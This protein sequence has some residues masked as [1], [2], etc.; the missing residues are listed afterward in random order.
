MK[1]AD[2]LQSSV[3]PI[4][5]T[6]VGMQIRKV[7]LFSFIV[8]SQAKKPTFVSPEVMVFHEADRFC[9]QHGGHLAQPAT[10]RDTYFDSREEVSRYWVGV[11]TARSGARFW[12]NGTAVPW[13]HYSYHDRN[14]CRLEKCFMVMRS[15]DH[16]WL[17]ALDD[18]EQ[19]QALCEPSSGA[20]TM[21]EEIYIER[22]VTERPVPEKSL[23]KLP[24]PK[25]PVSRQPLPEQPVS[26]QPVRNQPVP[27]PVPNP[28][29]KTSSVQDIINFSVGILLAV[30]AV[31]FF[32]AILTLIYNKRK[33]AA[34]KRSRPSRK[35][36]AVYAEVV[37]DG[38]QAVPEYLELNAYEAIATSFIRQELYVDTRED[39]DEGGYMVCAAGRNVE[40]RVSKTACP[41]G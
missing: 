5:L 41:T 39:V 14:L 28:A 7:I 8:V 6:V 25:Q 29:I 22:S 37:Y 21:V 2:Y 30:L 31:G 36:G 10:A 24:V 9:K 38:T 4:R 3:K 11:Y 27:E 15:P 32:A 40:P 26:R 1:P 17:Y 16:V 34:L 35:I 23:V 19:Y 12:T 13:W 20:N 33:V 18:D